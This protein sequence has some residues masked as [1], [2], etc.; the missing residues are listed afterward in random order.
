MTKHLVRRI[1]IALQDSCK[2]LFIDAPSQ[3]CK[4]SVTLVLVESDPS[5]VLID[6]PH[7][8]R[9]TRGHTPLTRQT[10]DSS[11]MHTGTLRCLFTLIIR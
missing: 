3:V 2:S 11:H 4:V 8:S 7:A 5:D 1:Q 9:H 6:G 10:L